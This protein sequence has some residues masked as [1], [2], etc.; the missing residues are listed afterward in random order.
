MKIRGTTM[1]ILAASML[2]GAAWA[3]PER[4]GGRP[5]PDG[6]PPRLDEPPVDR[7]KLKEEL[8]RRLEETKKT[9]ARLEQALARLNEGADPSEVR[10]ETIQSR[11]R[12][13]MRRQGRDN[14]QGAAGD[15]RP[16]EGRPGDKGGPPQGPGE[17]K[18]TPEERNRMLTFL[19]EH[20]P[21]MGKRMRDAMA[22]N[23]RVGEGLLSKLAPKLRELEATRRSQP[24][25]F[26]LK[27]N[28]L[29]ATITLQETARTWRAKLH[30]KNASDDDR[31]E[32][33]KALTDAVGEQ[34][35]ARLGLRQQEL[36]FLEKRIE[37]AKH[38]IDDMQSK[39]EVRISEEVDRWMGDLTSPDPD[40]PG[41]IDK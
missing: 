28:D 35:D 17:H 12:D 9:Q 29:R 4:G 13:R 27:L 24:E 14:P 31:A 26:D 32:A 16:D 3:Q 38:E 7:V 22:E 18:T 11:F 2:A 20:L 10:R 15:V 25:M 8:T 41:R 1:A 30:D 6:P 21:R 34:F 23:P 5:D 37:G 39:R 33:R 40:R 36:K 19:D